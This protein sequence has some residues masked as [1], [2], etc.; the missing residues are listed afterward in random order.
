MVKKHVVGLGGFVFFPATFF[1]FA[2]HFGLYEVPEDPDN[3][4]QK[5][6]RSLDN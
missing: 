6:E 2:G 1:G 4:R 5:D 3:G